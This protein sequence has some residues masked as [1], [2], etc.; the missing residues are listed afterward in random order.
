[1][2]DA[3]ISDKMDITLRISVEFYSHGGNPRMMTE[4]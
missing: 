4:E 3:T 1:M 2:I